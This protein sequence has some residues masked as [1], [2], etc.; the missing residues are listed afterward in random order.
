VNNEDYNVSDFTELEY[1]NLL[2]IAKR[3]YSFEGFGNSSVEKH[4]IW[5][6]DVDYS[7]QRALK[8]AQI[9]HKEEVKATYYILLRSEFYN[10]FE[11]DIKNCIKNIIGLGH[12]IGL[13][14][15]IS[16]YLDKIGTENLLTFL[17]YEAEI[18]E[19]EFLITI[20]SFSFH[21]TSQL[22][23]SF[24]NDHYGRF[25]N[26]YSKT[27]MEKYQYCSDSTGFWVYERLN[28]VLQRN[29]IDFLQILTHPV[30]WV[31]EPML[32]RERILR[33]ING[34]AE[35]AINMYDDLLLSLGR[36]NAGKI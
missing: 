10:I 27:I 6:H 15:D 7:M 14:F 20:N 32:P 26:V 13:H 33:A 23:K 8:L 3:K 35:N 18:L 12:E 31:P 17:S 21:N 36:V 28:N 24:T 16:H 2:K 5:R 4:V 22:T 9:E 25:L 19:K 30:W 11:E 1:E 34:R 29:D